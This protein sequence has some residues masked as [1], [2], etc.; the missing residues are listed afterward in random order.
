M[1]T[2]VEIASAICAHLNSTPLALD[3]EAMRKY[4]PAYTLDELATLRVTVVPKSVAI[5]NAA[6]NTDYFEVAVDVAVQKQVQPDNLGEL[7]ALAAFIEQVADTL[8]H[9]RLPGYPAAAWQSLAAD[10]IFDPD[11]LSERN[12]FTA[13]LTVTYR[14]QR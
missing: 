3:F 12:V 1:T 2:A 8:R 7:D 10:P 9:Q 4:R 5:S 14:V 11:H 6:R 13:V